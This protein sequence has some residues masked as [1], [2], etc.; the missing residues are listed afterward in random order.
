MHNMGNTC[1]QSAVIQCL[2]HCLPFQQYFL[3]DIRH[4]HQV[5]EMYRSPKKTDT[6]CIGCEVDKLVLDYYGSTQGVPVRIVLDESRNTTSEANSLPSHDD[7]DKTLMR[8]YYPGKPLVTNELLSSVWKKEGYAHLAGYKQQDA[9][10]FLH[11]FMDILGKDLLRLETALARK[12]EE[13]PYDMIKYL[14]GGTLQSVLICQSCGSKRSQSEPFMSLSLPLLNHTGLP[15][16]ERKKQ[17]SL[18]QCVEQFTSAEDL[19]DAV[20]CPS[21]H[22]KTKTKKQHVVSALPKVL[23]FHLKRFDATNS[24]KIEDFVPFPVRLNMGTYL[25]HW[26]G[27]WMPSDGAPDVV[28]TLTPNILYDLFGTVNHFGTANSGHYVSNVK[29]GEQW[30]HCNDAHISHADEAEV[31]QESA[32]LLFYLRRS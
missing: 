22:E 12:K 13:T 27:S 3:K 15:V 6:P 21:C 24:K 11:G 1:Y 2:L 18:E 30:F 20:D 26:K 5:C 17:P 31:L 32:Y 10:E 8:E 25:P 4:D 16:E 29:I 7:K 23:C 19:G 14:L 28:N 9:H